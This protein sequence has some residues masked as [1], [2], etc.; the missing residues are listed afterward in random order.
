MDDFRK[1]QKKECFDGSKNKRG[2]YGC[3]CC[4]KI[5]GLNGHKKHTRRLARVRLKEKDQ[6][7]TREET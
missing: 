6:N 1:E 2:K 5:R 7:E 3:S 4:R